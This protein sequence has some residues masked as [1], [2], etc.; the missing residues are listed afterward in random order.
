[1]SKKA[2]REK[3]KKEKTNEH[4]RR[5]VDKLYSLSFLS[6]SLTGAEGAEVL[7]RL[8]DDVG[9]ELFVRFVH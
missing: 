4:D 6:L 1:M 8:G 9:T 3:Q 5:S 2:S 7:G